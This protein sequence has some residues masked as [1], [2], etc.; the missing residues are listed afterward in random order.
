[1]SRIK[2]PSVAGQFYP[3]DKKALSQTVQQLLSKA[4]FTNEN[5]KAIIAPHA[6]YIYSGE[7]AANAYAF[8]STMKSSIN[9]VVILGPAHRYPVP[10]LAV[11]SYLYFATPLGDI[12][13]DNHLKQTILCLPQVSELDV[14]FTS[15]HCLEVQFP[16]LQILLDDFKILPILVGDADHAEVAEVLE[17]VWGGDETLIVISSD[18]SHYLQYQQAKKVDALTTQAIVEKKFEQ[19]DYESAC[20]RVPIS[21]LLN[22]ARR[23]NFQVVNLDLRNSGDTQGD[24]DRV[25]GYGAFHIFEGA[26]E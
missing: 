24:R 19:L 17:K 22:L 5:P 7:I 26:K 25:V 3:G 23:R 11:S 8:L 10:R 20:G 12:P 15:E 13:V 1:M 6:G 16:F 4:K 18:L 21:G 9:R 2:Q 14:A